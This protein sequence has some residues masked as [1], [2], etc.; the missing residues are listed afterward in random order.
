MVKKLKLIFFY[1]CID[2]CYIEDPMNTYDVAPPVVSAIE[3]LIVE[4]G[5]NTT[6]DNVLKYIFSNNGI[7]GK[8][9]AWSIAQ[10]DVRRPKWCRCRVKFINGIG[11]LERQCVGCE[12]RCMECSEC[13]RI[14][15]QE[16]KKPD[17]MG[18][19]NYILQECPLCGTP[20]LQI[21]CRKCRSVTCAGECVGV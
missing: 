10:T 13:Y 2:T 5:A 20:S 18:H 4:L 9:V 7:T 12:K 11:G 8:E 15:L 19:T 3:K 14:Y 17:P 16:I 6:V 21:C 1:N